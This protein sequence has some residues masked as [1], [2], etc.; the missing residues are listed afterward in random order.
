MTFVSRWLGHVAVLI[1]VGAVVGCA[2]PSY[3]PLKPDTVTKIHATRIHAGISQEEIAPTV[4]KSHVATYGSGKP[5]LAL[6]DAG[7]ESIRMATAN[8]LVEPIRKEVADYDFRT[9]FFDRLRDTAPALTRLNVTSVTTAPKELS[10]D[11]LVELRKKSVENDVMVLTSA[12]S[13]SPDFLVVT[14]VSRAEI[15]MRD[16]EE[17]IFRSAYHYE[18]PPVAGAKSRE[19]AAKAWA[20][21]R[22]G[23]L[24]A[25][26]TEGIDETMRML[27]VDLG[28]PASP[29][30]GS[31]TSNPP[32]AASTGSRTIVR[33]ADGI[34]YSTSSEPFFKVTAPAASK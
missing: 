3:I 15:W 32:A 12:Y 31:T 8:Q 33:G 2:K 30:G 10:S 19:E 14:V 16:R 22:G 13:L 34:M 17:P 27:T 18:T 28:S 6:I 29:S 5:L 1:V 11:E 9:H 20:A 24:R 7:I 4:E 21:D 23:A 25:A 26:L